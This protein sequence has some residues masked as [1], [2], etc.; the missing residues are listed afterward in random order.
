M[1]RCGE[2]LNLPKDEVNVVRCLRCERAF[3]FTWDPKR[4]K[5]YLTG[6]TFQLGW[7]K[8]R[9]TVRKNVEIIP[10]TMEI[11]NHLNTN[12][13]IGDGGF[14]DGKQ[15]RLAP[16]TRSLILKSIEKAKKGKR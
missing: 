10:F 9:G 14:M 15:D 16:R 7:L 12:P 8:D 5:K 3:F 4:S 11:Y 6:M 2:E 1:C 13:Q